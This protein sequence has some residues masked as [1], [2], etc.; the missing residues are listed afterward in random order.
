VSAENLSE[1]ENVLN[2]M[3]GFSS[4]EK[5]NNVLQL[6]FSNGN[7][8]AAAINQYCFQNNIALNHLQAKKK[9]LETKFLELTN[10]Q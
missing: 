2:R 4:I 6:F 10:K 3:G 1:L 5:H 7:A 9:S 8:N